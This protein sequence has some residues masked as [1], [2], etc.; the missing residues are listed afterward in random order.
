MRCSGMIL[1]LFGRGYL[2]QRERGALDRD[3]P[4]RALLDP[5]ELLQY[6]LAVNHATRHVVERLR[7][8][9]QGRSRHHR[10]RLP[11]RVVLS[12][13][14]TVQDRTRGRDGLARR[15][16]ALPYTHLA[17]VPCETPRE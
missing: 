10:R 13:Q 5:A 4:A 16:G 15:Q 3:A 12:G 14:I 2:Q 6:L 7:R 8:K 9:Q 1:L 17:D 11:V